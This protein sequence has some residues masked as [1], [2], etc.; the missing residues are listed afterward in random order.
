MRITRSLEAS[1]TKT[2]HELCHRRLAQVDRQV[3]PEK[4]LRKNFGGGIRLCKCAGYRSEAADSERS[5]ELC[6][7]AAD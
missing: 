5:G 7:R 6:G 2:V 1:R 4:V 3:E